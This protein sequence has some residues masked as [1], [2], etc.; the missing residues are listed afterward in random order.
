MHDIENTDAMPRFRTADD[1]AE[2]D[3]DA[4]AIIG[5]GQPY[6]LYLSLLVLSA[7][8]SLPLPGGGPLAS[9]SRLALI[10]CRYRLITRSKRTL[11]FA[12]CCR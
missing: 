6:Y 11:T 1:G 12:A 4:V 7:T 2:I 3:Q 8:Y 5:A 9:S 10:A